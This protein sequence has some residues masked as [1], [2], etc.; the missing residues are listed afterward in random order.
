MPNA[1]QNNAIVLDVLKVMAV[2]VP[3]TVSHARTVL[4]A[5]LLRSAVRTLAVLVNATAPVA[6]VEQAVPVLFLVAVARIVLAATLVSFLCARL[7]A[8]LSNAI[9]KDACLAM[10]ALAPLIV[11]VAMSVLVASRA[12]LVAVVVH[13]V[14]A[15][16]KT[17]LALMTALVMLS[18][19]PVVLVAH[20]VSA[21]ATTVMAKLPVAAMMLQLKHVV[22]KIAAMTKLLASALQEKPVNAVDAATRLLP[23]E[24][25]AKSLK[26][27]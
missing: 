5:M 25:A 4:A 16:V 8:L 14:N 9:A 18:K 15:L 19:Y 1:P 27:L 12:R 13:L 7:S 23:E 6:R 22:K 21:L 3:P 24:L 10:D 2:L 26:T 20:Q 11:D 17:A